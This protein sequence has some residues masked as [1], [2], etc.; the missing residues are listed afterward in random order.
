MLSEQCLTVN[1][2][3]VCSCCV[4]RDKADGFERAK[5]K[6]EMSEKN[7]QKDDAAHSSAITTHN[8]QQVCHTSLHII[9]KSHHMVTY[10]IHFNL[11]HLSIIIK[12]Q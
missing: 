6:K 11:D 8:I 3:V 12:V 2:A 1:V 5:K 10:I 7:G 9:I 4:G